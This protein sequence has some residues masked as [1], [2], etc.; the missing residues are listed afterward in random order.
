MA[1]IQQLLDDVNLRYRNTFTIPQKLVWMNEEQR[2]LFDILQIESAPFL[3]T[4]TA[5]L[6][7][8]PIPSE[9]EVQRIKTISIQ[10]SDSEYIPLPFKRNDDNEVASETE[11]WY[12][13]VG[14][15]FFFHVPGGAIEG[16]SIYIYHD[17]KPTEISDTALGEEPD[18]PKKYQEILKLGTLERIA[19]AR[20]DIGMKNN[21]ASEKEQRIADVLWDMK[22]N[23]PEFSSAMNVLPRIRR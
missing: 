5:G 22:M 19:A 13:V 6:S 21:F 23:E 7:V 10:A 2:D 14:E 4:M 1:T 17:K 8:Y 11:Y 9:I 3:L 12:T 15:V 18:T 20:K 16:R